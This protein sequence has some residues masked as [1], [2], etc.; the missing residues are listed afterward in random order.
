MKTKKKIVVHSN[1][2]KALTGFG[3]HKANLLKYLYKTGKYE[4]IEIANARKFSDPRLETLPWKCYGGLPDD[5]DE[6]HKASQKPETARDAGYGSLVIDK[7]IEIEKPDIYLGIEDI[8]AFDG[9]HGKPWWNQVNCVVHTTLDS[10]PIL[11][12]AIDA[13]PKIQ[14]YLVWA[15]FAERELKK[16]GHNHV[17][18][19][20]GTLDADNFRKLDEEYRKSIRTHFGL[21][22]SF[23]VGF[24]FRNQLRKSV[25]NLLDGFKLFVDSNPK[26]NAKL[27][28]HTNWGEGWDIPRLI[29][30]KKI[31][32]ELVVTTYVC[33]KCHN[34]YVAPF[35]FHKCNCSVCGG[36]ATVETVNIKEGVDEGQLNEIYNLMDVYCHAFTSGGQEIP[37]QEAKLCELITLA[38]NYS[39]GEDAV[40]EGSGG[41][42]LEWAEYREP[43]TQFIKASTSAISICDKIKEVHIMEDKARERMGAKARQYV[44]DNYSIEVVGK[45]FE[46]LFDSFEE[47]NW[48]K[49]VTKCVKKRN[50]DFVPDMALGDKEFVLSL[51]H[52]VLKYEDMDDKDGGFKY[53]MNELRVGK[54]RGEIVLLFKDIAHKENGDLFKQSLEE[55][56]DQDRDN[57]R[58]AFIA[59]GVPEEVMLTT[60]IIKGIKEKYPDHDIYYFTHKTFFPILDEMDEIHKLCETHEEMKNAFYFEGVGEKKGYFDIAFTPQHEAQHLVNF[61]HHGKD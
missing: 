58:I 31:P 52:N 47:V 44:I 12:D 61:S 23:V 36:V 46:E 43:G 38:T 6:M 26:A 19:I 57:K 50:P 21:Q 25:P 1:H 42:P 35:S 32:N 16:L 10:L 18:T 20:H 30:E 49:L 17:K 15:S 39:C 22:D 40:K 60:G 7:I 5:D 53:W 51:Y 2:C 48:D 59:E 14:N 34:Y 3:K 45:K 11:R 28:L 24:V 37:I 54:S 41:I 55:I 4:I 56:V 29:E 27:L 13:A 8:W 33:H 9:Y